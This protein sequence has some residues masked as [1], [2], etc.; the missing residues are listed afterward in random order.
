VTT[1]APSGPAKRSKRM[2]GFYVSIGVVLALFVGG[3]FAWTPLKLGYAIYRVQRTDYSKRH[4]GDLI[5][6]VRRHGLP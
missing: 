1:P 3:W 2:L 5:A 6:G 4:R